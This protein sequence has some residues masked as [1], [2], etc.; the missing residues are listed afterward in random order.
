MAPDQKCL[1]MTRSGHSGM[2]V[3]KAIITL[4]IQGQ[5]VDP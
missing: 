3:V 5:N 1:L 4:F 2:Y